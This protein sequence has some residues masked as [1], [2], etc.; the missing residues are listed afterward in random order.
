M[1]EILTPTKNKVLVV[2]GK[3]MKMMGLGFCNGNG[4][5]RVVCGHC[6]SEIRD[7]ENCYYIGCLNDVFCEE[8][9]QSRGTQIR[10]YAE[11]EKYEVRNIENIKDIYALTVESGNDLTGIENFSIESLDEFLSDVFSDKP[12]ETDNDDEPS[13]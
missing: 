5:H 10:H 6:N 8:C 1:E 2:T 12:I 7:D 13:L 11:D 4:T 9:Y 3:E